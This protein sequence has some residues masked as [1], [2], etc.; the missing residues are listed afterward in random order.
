MK[1]TGDGIMAAFDSAGDALRW[2]RDCLDE[3]DR[4]EGDPRIMV[5]IGLASGIPVDHNDDLYGETVVLASRLC[6]RASPSCALVAES[7]YPAAVELG[8][9]LAGPRM[10]RL[11]GFPEPVPAFVLGDPGRNG[12]ARGGSLWDRIRNLFRR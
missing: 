11:K 6:D 4:L 5:R 12:E 8:L 10:E 2:A 1:H 9:D 7:V 3:F